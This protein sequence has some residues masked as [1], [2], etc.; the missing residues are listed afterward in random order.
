MKNCGEDPD[1]LCAMIEN[2]ADHY[3]VRKFYIFHPNKQQAQ[4]FHFF[5]CLFVCLFPCLCLFLYL[6]FFFFFLH[7]CCYF[8]VSTKDVMS[9]LHVT[10]PCHLP[11][12]VPSKIALVDSSTVQQLVKQLKNTSIYRFPQSFCRACAIV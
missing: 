9:P 1:K 2:I 8:R 10:S 11:H 4:L 12:Y 3:Q 6:Y 7:P 5:V